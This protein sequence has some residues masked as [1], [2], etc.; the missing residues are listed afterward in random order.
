MIREIDVC[1]DLSDC[2]VSAAAVSN[3]LRNWARPESLGVIA[4]RV[5]GI[6]APGGLPPQPLALPPEWTCRES[7]SSAS[8]VSAAFAEA[9][10]HAVP[11]LL[12]SGPVEVTNEAIGVLRQGLHRDPMIGFAVPRIRCVD[13]CCFARLSR[14]GLGAT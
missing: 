5:T 12:L 6:V 4:R 3:A 11:L 14:H 2:T 8:A 13:G 1:A 7:E 9:G 10:R